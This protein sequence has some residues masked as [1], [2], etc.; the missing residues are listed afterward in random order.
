ME[1]VARGSDRGFFVDLN[2]LRGILSTLE[3]KFPSEEFTQRQSQIRVSF[4]D[5]SSQAIGDVDALG[6]L[7][8]AGHKEIIELSAVFEG[9]QGD[10]RTS[11]AALWLRAA[12]DRGEKIKPISYEIISNDQNWTKATQ[13]DLDEFVRSIERFDFSSLSR[14]MQFSLLLVAMSF[15]IVFMMLG[16]ERQINVSDVSLNESKRQLADKPVTFGEAVYDYAAWEVHK[17]Q[18]EHI[19]VF[20]IIMTFVPM[21]A[22]V[23]IQREFIATLFKPHIFYFGGMISIVNQRRSAHAVVWGA[24]VLGIAVGLVANYLGKE[25]FHL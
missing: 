15:I 11:R 19:P 23:L 22:S 5:G 21:L 12:A 24:V 3:L 1:E 20:V 25:I 10:A 18:R 13:L 9:Q 8:N 2:S 4:K 7:T 6:S 14:M 16:P 17:E